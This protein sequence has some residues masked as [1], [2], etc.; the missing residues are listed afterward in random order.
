MARPTPGAGGL[1]PLGGQQPQQ[2]LVV[3][4]GADD[5]QRGA[6]RYQD[7]LGHPQDG[8]RAVRLD[9]LHHR[10]DGLDLA[11]R[12]ELLAGPLENRTVNRPSIDTLLSTSYHVSLFLGNCS[13]K[14]IRRA[15]LSDG[16]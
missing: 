1:I 10:F 5:R 7:A 14:L 11:Q 12:E 13:H 3:Q 8:L 2:P 9:L 15:T 16:T 6:L 4:I